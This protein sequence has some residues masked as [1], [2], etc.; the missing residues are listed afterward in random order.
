MR[1]TAARSSFGPTLTLIAARVLSFAVTFLIPV[2]L[3]R[4]FD[5]ATFGAY[6]QVFLLYVVLYAI[7]QVGMAE[8]LY[9]FIPSNPAKGG[10]I[11]LNAVIVLAISGGICVAVLT[12][13][14]SDVA[15]WLGNP[16]VAPYILPIGVF[17][18]FML[19]TAVLE[20]SM[21]AAKHYVLAAWTYFSSDLLRSAFLIVPAL[22][23]RKLEA[24][25][26]GAIVFASLRFVYCA[27]YL[28]REFGAK[29]SVDWASLRRQLSYALPFELAIIV[30]TLQT[31]YHQYTVSHHFGAIAFATYSVGCL[32][33][34]F[35]D[36]VAGP[37]ANVMMVRMAEEMTADRSRNV[38]T[39]WRETTRR[40]ALVF[41]PLFALLLVSAREIILLLFT[42]RYA[43]AI[44]IFMLWAAV[45]PL[46]VFQTDSLLRV[47]AR[48]RFILFV[49]ILRLA[50]IAGLIGASISTIGLRGAV[51]ITLLALVVS[52]GLS[53][54]RALSLMHARAR[55]IVPWG[56]LAAIGAA[57]AAACLPAWIVKTQ[58]PLPLAPLLVAM[59]GVFSLAYFALLFEFE[60]LSEAER[61]T[62]AGWLPV[63]AW[64][65]RPEQVQIVRGAE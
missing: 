21:V 45:V 38:L 8:S 58:M 10:G 2:I 34:P 42:E 43:A 49:N 54:T 62:L 15:R 65:Q 31:N 26:A 40:L 61:R 30:D 11:V 4:I 37:A 20:I 24:V 55:E 23:F 32:Q 48:T 44:P 7:A 60:L 63:L 1:M 56:N 33:L 16:A 19:I 52:K 51:L 14:S 6:K 36:F 59:G 28:V 9:Y 29:L 25:L 64:R 22:V 27:G 50:M 17:L 57:S 46:A 12:A 39:I 47:F 53:L 5:Q 35:V 13:R 18:L 41:F 3:V